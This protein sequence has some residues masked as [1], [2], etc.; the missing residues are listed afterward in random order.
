ML[1]VRSQILVFNNCEI[2]VVQCIAYKMD[3]VFIGSII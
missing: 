3:F 1:P 2:I